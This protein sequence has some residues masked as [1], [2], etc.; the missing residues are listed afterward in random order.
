MDPTARRARRA[1]Y[2]L[3]PLAGIAPLSIAAYLPALP[4]LE[5]SLGT[6]ASLVQ[7]T[8]AA[9][10]V[11]LALGQ[12]VQGR[13]SDRYGRRPVLLGGLALYAASRPISRARRSR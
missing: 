9:Y 1:L 8:M 3:G 2:V 7:L 13:L 11:G 5:R 12:F 6:T 10:L 4:A